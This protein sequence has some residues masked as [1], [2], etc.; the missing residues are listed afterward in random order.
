MVTRILVVVGTPLPDTLCHSLAAA[1]VDRPDE[2]GS[3]REPAMPGRSNYVC[4]AADYAEFA[5]KLV[6][7][8]YLQSLKP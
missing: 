4:E 2:Y 7:P 1:Y 3:R 6:N 5:E 8:S